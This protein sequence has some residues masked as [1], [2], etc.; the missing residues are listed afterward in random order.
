M[1]SDEACS[2]STQLAKHIVMQTT[3]WQAACT[4]TAW[5]KR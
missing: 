4:T 1:T 5:F 2:V 3:A